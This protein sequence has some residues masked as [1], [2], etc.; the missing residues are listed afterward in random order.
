MPHRPFGL[1]NREL[2]VLEL[3]C[4]GLTNLEIA[5]RCSIT[6]GVVKLHLHHAYEKLGVQGRMQAARVV[7]SL[8]GVRDTRMRRSESLDGLLAELLPHMA[9]EVR[10]NGEVLFRIGEPGDTLYYLQQ[11]RVRFPELGT[12][13]GAGTLFGEVGIFAPGRA[14]TSSALCVTT[15]HLF[16]LSAD[17]AKAI[18]FANPRFGYYMVRLIAE[19]LS[20]ERASKA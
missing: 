3:A 2:E 17:Q 18:C 5:C 13:V 4:D 8:H 11:G 14:R 7:Q 19:R 1:T 12:E 10:R 6:E 15:T 20:E 9:Y 16:R